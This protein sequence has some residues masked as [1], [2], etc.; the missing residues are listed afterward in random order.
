MARIGIDCRFA[1]AFGGLGRYTREL[2]TAMLKTEESLNEYV[3]FVQDPTEEWLRGISEK[4]EVIKAPYAHYSFAEQ[5][6]FPRVLNKAH[7]DLL[8]VPHFNV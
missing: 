2:V 5:I 7:L 3:L 1:S 8:F 6:L 4:H